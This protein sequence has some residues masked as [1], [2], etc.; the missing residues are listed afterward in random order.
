MAY[1]RFLAYLYKEISKAFTNRNEAWKSPEIVSFK[2]K[3]TLLSCEKI[4]L[5]LLNKH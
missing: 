5:N 4:K 2:G 1:L 3:S